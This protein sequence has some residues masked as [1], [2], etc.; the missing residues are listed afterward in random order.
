MKKILLVED[1]VNVV[2]FIKK[3]LTEEDFEVSVALDGNSGV[4]MA[5]SSDYDLIILDIM[6]PDK[7]GIEVCK[8]LRNNQIQ[9]PILFLTALNTADN[10]ALGLNSGAD[11]YLAKPFKF[12]ELVAR[13]KALLRRAS[14]GGGEAKAKENVYVVAN[15]KVDDDSKTVERNGELISLTATEYRLLVT[16]LK[17]K[18]KVLSRV[19]LL[20][21]AWDIN[22]NLATNVVDVYINYLRK[23]LDSAYEPKL[24]HTVIGMGYVLREA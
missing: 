23:K 22:F 14:Q 10:I 2:S 9:V 18:G 17:N 8:E 4:Q 13:I 3:G 19:D 7:N 20:E 5:L 16:L 15:L 24:I 6:L 12:I 21:S 11:D 1:E